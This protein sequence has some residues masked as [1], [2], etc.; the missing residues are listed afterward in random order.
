MSTTP[1]SVPVPA[2]APARGGGALK[3]AATRLLWSLVLPAGSSPQAVGASISIV[4]AE[5]AVRHLIGFLRIH[6]LVNVRGVALD[7]GSQDLRVAVAAIL[8]P[9]QG[10]PEVSRAAE[11]S[12]WEGALGSA[13]LRNLRREASVVSARQML[14]ALQATL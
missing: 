4:V 7:E 13:V 11:L 9:P 5:A 12:R 3:R 1:L 2:P 14:A 8:E 6:D 10:E